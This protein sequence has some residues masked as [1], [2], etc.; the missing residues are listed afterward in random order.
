MENSSNFVNILFLFPLIV[1]WFQNPEISDNF[2]E[3]KYIIYNIYIIYKINKNHSNFA[4]KVV[5]EIFEWTFFKK[6]KVLIYLP[7]K[8]K[9]N[10]KKH[11]VMK[12]FYYAN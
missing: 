4:S 8:F 9:K 11:L 6:L 1:L 2:C 5:F 7:K 10:S 3:K 12:I